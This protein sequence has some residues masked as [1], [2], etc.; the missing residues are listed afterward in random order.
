MR[1]LLIDSLPSSMRTTNDHFFRSSYKKYLGS[2]LLLGVMALYCFTV[3]ILEL[4]FP[5]CPSYMVQNQCCT[6]GEFAQDFEGRRETTAL[7]FFLENQGCL[8]A[9][10]QFTH[11]VTDTAAYFVAVGH[12]PDQQVLQLP[13]NLL[14]QDL[15][16]LNQM[17]YSLVG[18][19]RAQLLLHVTS[20]AAAGG[21]R[22]TWIP[23]C[24]Y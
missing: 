9:F 23:M 18:E 3:T 15:L 16:V 17:C 5:D 8:Q 1:T 22:L 24:P 19:T 14:L 4:H 20:V 6:Q 11:A 10:R 13:S 7:I 21:E 12:L 2:D